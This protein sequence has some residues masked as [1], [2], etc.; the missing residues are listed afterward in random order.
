MG[1][2]K[3]SKEM[4]SLETVDHTLLKAFQRP[5]AK[6][7][8][9]LQAMGTTRTA[10]WRLF[11]PSTE[12]VL[13]LGFDADVQRVIEQL[14]AGTATTLHT[15]KFPGMRQGSRRIEG[16]GL[17]PQVETRAN[18]ADFRCRV[19]GCP[20]GLPCPMMVRQGT[21]GGFAWARNL[22][23]VDIERAFIHPGRCRARV[24]QFL[25]ALKAGTA[26]AGSTL[27]P[28]SKKPQP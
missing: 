5:L 25:G 15:V 16:D 28:V 20:G 19:C 1:P 10:S 24:R 8:I 9:E 11:Q 14:E 22:E 4:R 26:M 3:T 18:N 7:G 27:Q 6:H 12:E 2:R 23:P 17:G 21:A 13:P